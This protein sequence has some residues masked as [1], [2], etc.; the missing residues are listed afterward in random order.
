MEEHD[1]DRLNV[2][3]DGQF[4]PESRSTTQSLPPVDGGRAAWLFML[5]CFMIELVLWVCLDR[6]QYG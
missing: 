4:A 1:L 2:T 5:G 3:N 6:L